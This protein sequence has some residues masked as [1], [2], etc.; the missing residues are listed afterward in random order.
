MRPAIKTFLASA[1]SLAQVIR[2]LQQ[3]VLLERGLDHCLS[4]TPLFRLPGVFADDSSAS[5]AKGRGRGGAGSSGVVKAN[6]GKLQGSKGVT[7]AGK[8]RKQ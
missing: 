4:L 3:L 2:R 7:P 5:A 6:A 8:R 1:L